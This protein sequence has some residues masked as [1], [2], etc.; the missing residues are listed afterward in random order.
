M[1]H[2]LAPRL[3]EVLTGYCRPI[4][5]GDYV[6]IRSNTLAAEFIPALFTAILQRGGHPSLALDLPELDELFLLHASDAQLD[7]IDPAAQTRLERADV[8]LSIWAPENP[9]ALTAIPPE[10][11][12]RAQQ[13]QA[14]LRQMYL[15]RVDD[16]SLRWNICAWPTEAAAQQ[17]HMSARAYREFVYRAAGL[18]QPDP[19]AYWTGF[20]ERQARLQAWLADKSHVEVR[21]PGIALTLEYARRHWRSSYGERNFP[22]GEIYTAPVEDSVNG[23]VAFSF[24]T[25]YGGR[26]VSGA[27]L[28][29]K[30]GLCVEATAERGEDFLLSQLD[31][32]AGARRLGEFAIGTNWGVD[33]VTG[34]TLFDEKMGGTIH[35][36]LGNGYVQT[37]SQNKSA[38]HWDMVHDMRDGGEIWIDGTLFY[39][40][41]EFMVE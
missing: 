39:R 27:V 28:T 34:N 15:Q 22:D 31:L 24:P 8:L 7:F 33:R 10:R 18:H 17:A 20:R 23:R 9:H 29:F 36:A 30:D 32:D 19:V 35:M 2:D 12:V 37:G 26:E 11:M 6:V 25:Y 16:D 14:P 3:A 4:Q 21:G 41:G 1:T 38:I 5:P 40:A 13:G